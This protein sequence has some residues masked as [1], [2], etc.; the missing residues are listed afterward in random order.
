MRVRKAVIP[1]AGLGTRLLPASKSVPK[2]MIPL[3][4]RPAIQY[5]VEE[6]VR[7]GIRDV[8]IVTG[9]GKATME[10]HFDRSL[11]LEERLE[12]SGKAEELEEVRRV[13]S[14][15]DVH[16]VRQKEALGLGHAVGT[17][18]AHVGDEP[19]AVLLPDEIVPA[20]IR[21]EPPLLERMMEVHEREGA[22][23]VAVRRV[24]HDRV[25]AY[26][27]VAPEGD[28]VDDFV[29]VIDLVEK[30]AVADAPSDLGAVGRYILGPEVF[31]AIDAT[32]PGAGGEIQLTDGIRALVGSPG[33]YAYLHRGPIYD[34][35]KRLDYVK[36]TLQ[37]ALR[38]DDV[39]PP[40]KAW[41]RELLEG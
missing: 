29:K 19:F 1:A 27:I 3:V 6:C 14:M 13:A 10:D 5:V 24:P 41:L 30:P 33:V 8:L 28:L 40:L 11:E 21:A 23:V 16:Y 39:G 2:E 17:A 38:R 9:R 7:A 32:T 26:G 31:D 15:A 36:G 35:G 34:V 4:D 12:K 20:P 37:L 22:S 25:S 18:R